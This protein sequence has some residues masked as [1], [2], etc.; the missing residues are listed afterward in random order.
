MLLL[1]QGAA[2]AAP[3]RKKEKIPPELL[4]NT[5]ED[6]HGDRVE[7]FRTN[8]HGFGRHPENGPLPDSFCEA[9]HGD[10]RAHNE[11]GG[12]ASLIYVP[13]G[14]EG[15]DRACLKCHDQN[16]REPETIH[17]PLRTRVHQPN[18][19]HANSEMVNCLTCHSI[20][21]EEPRSPYL[22]R[23]NQEKLCAICH[24]TEVASFRSQ[25]YSHR[26]GRGGMECSSCHDPHAGAGR[27][28]LRMT[29]TGELPCLSCHNEMRGPHAFEH[30]ETSDGGCLDC[31]D[32]HG[33]S[34]PKMLKRATVAQVCI[35]CHSPISNATFGS[36]PPSFHNLASPRY[37]NCTACHVKIHGSDRDP[38]LLE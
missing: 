31:H 9:C 26:L 24:P 22:L 35:E 20:Q 3:A 23:W 4:H 21:H 16:S 28:S 36:Q 19:V 30:G 37:Q 1:L 8:A 29:A 12:E 10:G 34:N 15:A 2:M 33:S 14:R 7:R 38:R 6:C 13:F 25:P 11:S 27:E 5:C 32:V 18:G 17:V